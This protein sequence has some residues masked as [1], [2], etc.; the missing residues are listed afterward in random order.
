[1]TNNDQV[2]LDQVLE[3][4]LKDRAPSMGKSEFFELFVSEQILKDY[5]LSDEELEGGIVGN[6]GDGGI[7]GIYVFANG[8]LVQEDFNPNGLKKT[9]SLM[10]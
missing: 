3:Q 5:D 9:S 1:M 6:G 8:E 2:I 10:W 7:D 4:Q